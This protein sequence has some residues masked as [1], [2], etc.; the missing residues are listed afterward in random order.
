MSSV[1]HCHH[2]VFE[3]ILVS[4]SLQR[5]NCIGDYISTYYK[6]RPCHSFVDGLSIGALMC[7]LK[8]LI[9]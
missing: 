6:V 1:P 5:L 3:D 4:F 7:I 2:L 9:N 8:S